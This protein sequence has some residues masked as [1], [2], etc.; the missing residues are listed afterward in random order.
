[1]VE[2]RLDELF[3]VLSE[4]RRAGGRVPVVVANPAPVRRAPVESLEAT[5]PPWYH[6]PPPWLQPQPS[7]RDDSMRSTVELL[8]VLLPLFA[9]Q[10][11]G[12]GGLS[13]DAVVGLLGSLQTLVSPATPPPPP[14]PPAEPEWLRLV[15]NPM[16]QAFLAQ[17]LGVDVAMVQAFAAM[18]AGGVDDEGGDGGLADLLAGVLAGEAAPAVGGDLAGCG[19]PPGGDTGSAGGGED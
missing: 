7:A 2:E 18:A 3:D 8:R 4:D 13:P 14:S 17:R 1:M 15:E 5:P 6:Q 19:D 10:P 12:T 16:V 9:H 11:A